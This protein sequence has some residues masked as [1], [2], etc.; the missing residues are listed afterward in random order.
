VVWFLKQERV[1]RMKMTVGLQP[2][3]L[4]GGNAVRLLYDL[5]N[6]FVTYLI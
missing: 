4:E 5:R 2:D 3:T 1:D 6:T